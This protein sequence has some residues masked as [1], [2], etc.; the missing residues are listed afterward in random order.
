MCT[1][2]I[3]K[4]GV[5]THT[6]SLKGW[7]SP[8]G[9]SKGIQEESASHHCFSFAPAAKKCIFDGSERFQINLLIASYDLR[10]IAKFHA[11]GTGSCSKALAE[12]S[13]Q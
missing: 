10:K 1:A 11:G 4:K 2:K 13:L 12:N 6:K 5:F 7:V 9:S 3:L 8:K